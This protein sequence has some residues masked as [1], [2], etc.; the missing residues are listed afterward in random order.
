MVM[1]HAGVAAK[2]T[3]YLEL[4]PLYNLMMFLAECKMNNLESIEGLSIEMRCSVRQVV[5][6]AGVAAKVAIKMMK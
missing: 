5:H 1:Y 6:H 2:V 3:F 4:M